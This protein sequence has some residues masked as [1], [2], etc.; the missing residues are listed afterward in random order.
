[1]NVQ[2]ATKH[3]FLFKKPS[4]DT[5]IDSRF[6]FSE[7]CSV[8]EVRVSEAR[9]GRELKSWMVVW[10]SSLLWET[11]VLKRRLFG[12]RKIGSMRTRV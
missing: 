8:W 3:G 6:I 12:E 9:Q 11:A 2:P 10:E 7:T 4:I 1:M 5:K